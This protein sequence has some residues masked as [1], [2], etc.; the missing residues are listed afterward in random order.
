MMLKLIS[1]FIKVIVAL[2]LLIFAAYNYDSVEL[3]F[4]RKYAVELP[5][6]LVMFITFLFGF[7]FGLLSRLFEAKRR[8][9]KK[10]DG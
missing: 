1:I 2:I 5:L 3:S 9:K 6:A 4:T 7:L 8:D 10:T